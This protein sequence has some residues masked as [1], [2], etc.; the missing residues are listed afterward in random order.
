MKNL[1][2]AELASPIQV[3]RYIE[4]FEVPRVRTYR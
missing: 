4:S 1:G 3:S 2:A